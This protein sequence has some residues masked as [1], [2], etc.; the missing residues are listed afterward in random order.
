MRIQRESSLTIMYIIKNNAYPINE[1]FPSLSMCNCHKKQWQNAKKQQHINASFYILF[2]NLGVKYC[3]E[4]SWDWPSYVLFKEQHD[5]SDTTD[6]S[7][8]IYNVL[9]TLKDRNT[10]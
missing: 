5:T 10:L 1:N 7:E 8:S 4:L 2:F 3:I 6:K 9:K